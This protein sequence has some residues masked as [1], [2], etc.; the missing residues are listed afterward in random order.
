MERTNP[1]PWVY[2]HNVK[3]NSS[4]CFN[5]PTFFFFSRF[6]GSQYRVRCIDLHGTIESIIM[7]IRPICYTLRD[8]RACSDLSLSLFLSEANKPLTL[9]WTILA[10]GR[11]GEASLAVSLERQRHF[12]LTFMQISQATRAHDTLAFDEFFKKDSLYQSFR[13]YLLYS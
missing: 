5:P 13:V 1:I 12:Q 9:P 6:R 3:C 10:T 11:M 7:A 4:I 2:L 8:R